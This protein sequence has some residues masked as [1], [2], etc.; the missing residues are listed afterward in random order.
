MAKSQAIARKRKGTRYGYFTSEEM[1]RRTPLQKFLLKFKRNWQLHLMMLLPLTY[2]ILFHYLPLY[3]VQIAFRDYN[4]LEGITNSDWVGLANFQRFFNNQR[5]SQYV[6]NTVTISLYTIAV[7]FPIPIILALILHVNEHPVLKK[8][9]Q[10][11]SYLPHF[12]ST[13]VL[14]GILNQVFKPFNGLVAVLARDIFDVSLTD[15]IRMNPDTFYHLYVW[16]G[17]WQG[18]GW[19]AILYVSALAGVPVE[20]HEAAKI[21]GASRWRRVLSVDLPAILPTICIMLILRFGSVMSVGYEKAYLMQNA[22]NV[23]KAKVISV[24]VYENGMNR[25]NNYSFGS[26]VGLMNS[27]INTSMVLLVNGIT[28]KLSDGE[29]GLF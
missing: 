24:Y 9:T 22:G 18:M 1:K 27:V 13:V 20:L 3:G 7:G 29:S 28:N 8:V 5:W 25:P 12:I 11:V 23:L 19:S 17:V 16:S 10:N 4:V 15:D 2:M 26:A 14:V 6:I 21:D